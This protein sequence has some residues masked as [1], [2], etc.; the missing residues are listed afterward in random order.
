M[1]R[2]KTKFEAFFSLSRHRRRWGAAKHVSNDLSYEALKH[3]F[4]EPSQGI[5]HKGRIESLDQHLANLRVEFAGEPE[6]LYEHAKLIVLIRREYDVRQTYAAFKRLW[7]AEGDFLCAKL[8]L[9]WLISAS[10]TIADHDEQM[11]TRSIAMMTSLLSTTVKIYETDRYISGRMAEPPKPE[12]V[13]DV[14]QTLHPLFDGMALF[15]VGE[16]DTLRNMRWR[17]G[18]F[19]GEGISGKIAQEVFAR[20]QVLDTA[21][22]RLRNLHTRKRTEW[23][24]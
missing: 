9:R 2:K 1:A 11:A 17:L 20:L 7:A 22:A 13:E 18:P 4:V 19:F 24:D 23:W 8:N 3:S 21:Y 10:D 5:P 6:L 14:R 12:L 15:R 16:D